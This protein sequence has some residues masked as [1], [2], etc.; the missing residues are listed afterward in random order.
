MDIFCKVTDLGLI[1]M[2]D[3]DLECKRKLKVGDTVLCKI[4]KPRNYEFH[5]KFFALI[6]LTFE[7][8]P[9]YMHAKYGIYS[10]EDLLTCLKLDIG[11]ASVI[12]H[13]GQQLIKEG[14]ISFAVMDD[15]EFEQFYNGCVKVILNKYL[16]GTTKPE[17]LHEI[18]QFM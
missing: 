10:E 2:Y 15:Y 17:L 14:S 8:L 6:R 1:P 13:N 16:R 3:S 5:K 7:N 9:E 4:T 11:L 12:E 18:H